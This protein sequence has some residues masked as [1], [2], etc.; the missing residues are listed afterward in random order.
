MRIMERLYHGL[1]GMC[2]GVLALCAGPAF[3]E[4]LRP[5][6]I[7]ALAYV[8][9]HGAEGAKFRAEQVYMVSVDSVARTCSG[10]LT[11]E[12]NGYR[13][14]ELVNVAVNDSEVAKGKIGVGAGAVA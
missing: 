7:T 2:L 12:S 11:A 13:L 5:D 9:D 3:A 10:S 6:L 1:I 8:T 4:D 14:S